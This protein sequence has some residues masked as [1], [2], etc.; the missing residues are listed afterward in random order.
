MRINGPAA[1]YSQDPAT[2]HAD[3]FDWCQ[4]LQATVRAELPPEASILDVGA[5]FGKYRILL[6]EYPNM[7]AA[8]VWEPYIEQ[9][10]L[11]D[12]YR[13]VYHADICDLAISPQWHP[14]DLV[15]LGDVLEHIDRERATPLVTHLTATCRE[16]FAIVPYCYPQGSEHGNPW[17]RHLQE[18]LT[19]DLM[20]TA[21]PTLTLAETEYQAGKPYR[22][23]YRARRD[24]A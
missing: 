10:Q 4:I 13:H 8:E 17:Q 22:G 3:V 11:R 12:R 23:F 5:G 19:P 16:V 1:G 15:I 7:D 24:P 2:R 18:D 6:P 20:T 14:Y 21:Y 9:E